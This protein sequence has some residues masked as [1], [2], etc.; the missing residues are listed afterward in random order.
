M[1]RS[2]DRGRHRI[3]DVVYDD[4]RIYGDGIIVS[5]DL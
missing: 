4:V 5:E 3:G 2:V 1:I